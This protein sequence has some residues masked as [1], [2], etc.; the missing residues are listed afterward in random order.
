MCCTATCQGPSTSSDMLSSSQELFTESL[1]S[2][3]R[4][5]VSAATSLQRRV[6]SALD[7]IGRKVKTHEESIWEAGWVSST[8]PTAYGLGPRPRPLM[9][10]CTSSPCCVSRLRLGSVSTSVGRHT[11]AR[12]RS[13]RFVLR[14]L[15]CGCQFRVSR[16]TL[17]LVSISSAVDRKCC[18]STSPT[19]R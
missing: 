11:E 12:G 19:P 17:H 9:E 15:G 14:R 6:V 8:A 3:V 18:V 1:Q 5:R 16:A 13:S 10:P 7:S 2:A 4:D